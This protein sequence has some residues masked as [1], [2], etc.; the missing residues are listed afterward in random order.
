LS[1]SRSADG[2][3]LDRVLALRP[4]LTLAA[5]ARLVGVSAAYC[6]TA[7]GSRGVLSPR[8]RSALLA[9]ASESESKAEES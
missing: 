8:V 1:V 6:S 7:R 9:L 4:E 3:L 5:L 2:A